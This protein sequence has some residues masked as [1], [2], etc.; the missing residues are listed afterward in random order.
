MGLGTDERYAKFFFT[1]QG[2]RSKL[3]ELR[4]ALEAERT[5]AYSTETSASVVTS[6]IAR[7]DLLVGQC[8]RLTNSSSAYW[9]L[10]E[11]KDSFV[12][13]LTNPY[14]LNDSDSDKAAVLFPDPT[15]GSIEAWL[16]D[17]SYKETAS[18]LQSNAVR[19]E[20]LNAL[21]AW[22]DAFAY[23]SAVMYPVWRYEDDLFS[24]EIKVGFLALIGEMVNRRFEVCFGANSPKSPA[25]SEL[26]LL[27]K[28]RA[29]HVLLDELGRTIPKEEYWTKIIDGEGLYARIASMNSKELKAFF[30]AELTRKHKQDCEYDTEEA[31]KQEQKSDGLFG[32]KSVVRV[33]EKSAAPPRSQKQK[34]PRRAKVTNS[35]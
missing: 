34:K 7:I 32:V 26:F 29:F 33:E 23:V 5:S 16:R 30:E 20:G 14:E 31:A 25:R 24:S 8:L 17:S 12:G 21:A 1:M 9:I 18:Y 15:A 22:W 35:H 2:W 19:H 4:R 27:L 3:N 10:G 11:N 6:W 13:L 28:H